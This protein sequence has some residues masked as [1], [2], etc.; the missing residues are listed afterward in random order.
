MT[1]KAKIVIL[2]HLSDSKIEMSVNTK[3]A[4]LRIDF[5]KYLILKHHDT[6]VE[7]DADAEYASFLKTKN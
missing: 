3:Q 7:I 6:N 1:V 4:N 2:S 5:A